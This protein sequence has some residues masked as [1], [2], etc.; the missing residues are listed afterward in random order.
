V[1]LL[2]EGRGAQA[3]QRILGRFATEPQPEEWFGMNPARTSRLPIAHFFATMV[4]RSSEISGGVQNIRA[5]R[6]TFKGTDNG[7][8]IKSNRDRSNN[9]G[10]FVFFDITMED[11]K[12]AILIANT[13]LRFPME[14]M[15]PIPLPA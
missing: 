5:E 3:F 1:I 4:S 13:I 15:H 9:I 6:I 14:M 10:N 8:R 2:L 11:V 7:I 12:T